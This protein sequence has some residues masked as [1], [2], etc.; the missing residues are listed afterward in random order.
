MVEEIR[1]DPFVPNDVNLGGEEPKNMVITG[2]LVPPHYNSCLADEA[3]LG[4]NMVR[5]IVKGTRLGRLIQVHFQGRKVFL[6][7]N[8]RPYCYYG[9]NRKVRCPIYRAHG[10]R[11]SFSYVPADAAELCLHDCVL[12]RMGASDELA[13]GRSTFMV[14]MSETSDIIQTATDKSLVILDERALDHPI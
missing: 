13:R 2:T 14:E 12:T 5:C 10:Y 7:P 11:P 9:A 4:P 6:C 8:D 3:S 1:T